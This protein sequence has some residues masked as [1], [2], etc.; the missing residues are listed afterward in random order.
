VNGGYEPS[1]VPVYADR[2]AR[3]AAYE[4]AQREGRPFFAVERYE[5]GYAITY[6][7]LPAGRELSKPACKELNERLTREVESVVEDAALPTTEVSK[8]VSESLG[9]VSF[10]ARERTA[11]QVAAT[12]SRTV[13]DE[14]N[15][16][17]ASRFDGPDGG[18]RR[19]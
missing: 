14:T 10:F 13:L 19:N 8:T 4:G 1:E 7:L 6:D 18:V 11:R 2:T 17:T 5:D 15:W 3:D 9:N 12:I 16:V